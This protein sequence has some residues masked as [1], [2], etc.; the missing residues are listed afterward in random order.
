M[1]LV[2]SSSPWGKFPPESPA[3]FKRVFEAYV[4]LRGLCRF[5]WLMSLYVAYVS[6]Y[7]LCI[8]LCGVSMCIMY[9]CVA[10]VS[11][12]GIDIHLY[13]IRIPDKLVQTSDFYKFV[14]IIITFNC[15]FKSPRLNSSL[16]YYATLLPHRCFHVTDYTS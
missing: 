2:G 16:T 1:S 13:H 5:V 14:F 12:C 8:L 3:L 9:R 15:V 6:L 7:G 4:P 10:Y 11:L